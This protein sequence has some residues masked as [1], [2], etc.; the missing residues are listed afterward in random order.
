MMLGMLSIEDILFL[1][2]LAATYKREQ[3]ITL[4]DSF[5]IALG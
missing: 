4:S 3:V 2:E 5:L 1:I